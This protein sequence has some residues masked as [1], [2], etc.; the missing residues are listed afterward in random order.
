MKTWLRLVPFVVGILLVTL[1]ASPVPRQAGDNPNPP[2]EIV[3][4][5][6]IHHSTGENWLTD[7]YG[8]L[9]RALDQNNYFVSDTNYGW[10]PDAI[11]DRTDIPNWT[12]WFAGENAPTYMDALL[13]E[14][15]QHASYT[16]TL[17]DPGG[18]NEIILFK[19]C[20]PN[21]ALEGNPNDPPNPDGWLSV[22][23]AKYVYNEI[24]RTFATRPDKMFVV[25]TAPPLSEGTYA[26]NARAFNQWLLNDWLRENKYSLNNV[27]VFDFYNVLTSPDA[28]H[29]YNNGQIEHLLGGQNTLYYPSG[30]DHPS[31][32]GSQKA[33][34]EFI[35]ML[36]IFYHRWKE[37]APDQSA[38]MPATEA[39]AESQPVTSSASGWI[40]D[41]DANSL[42]KASGWEGFYDEA[43][44]TSWTC[45]VE[46]GTGR[47]GNALHLDFNIAANSWGTCAAF[48]EGPQNWSTS[49]GLTFYFKS[50]GAGLLF[51]VDLYTGSSENRA[52]YVYT[53]EAPAES[54][55]DWVPMQLRWEDFHRASWEENGGAVFTQSDQIIGL[56][57]GA[58]TPQDAPN[59]GQIWM[60]DLQLSGAVPVAEQPEVAPTAAPDTQSG[61]SDEEQP[62][63]QPSLPCTGGVVLPLIF[64]GLVR[65]NDRK[66]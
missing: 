18:Q 4:L 10:G 58:T 50:A 21:S 44:S 34:E 57:L 1:A 49:D 42:P 52:T 12:E 11:G 33:T 56:A 36:N 31:E 66:R 2:E 9:G 15:G 14:S 48:F 54:A 23:H 19:S 60:D 59:T 13:G 41:F 20:F 55:T 37:N 6:F 38:P 65:F 63:G 40:D 28:H 43:T 47:S 32:S 24:L 3:K 51:D 5:I 64:L 46:A 61:D 27:F 53:I 7:G 29:R 25:I 26:T 62:A 22:G 39:P 35:P 17:S 45:E 16:R 30:D 8:N